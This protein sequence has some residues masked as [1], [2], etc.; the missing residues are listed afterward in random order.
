[1]VNIL[2]LKFYQI[3]TPYRLDDMPYRCLN[4]KIENKI[5]KALST[6]SM[7]VEKKLNVKKLNNIKY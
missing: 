4:L 1:M 5:S 6:F 3:S 2:L 7:Y